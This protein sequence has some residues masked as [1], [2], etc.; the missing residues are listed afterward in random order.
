MKNHQKLALIQAILDN[1]RAFAAVD[2]RSVDMHV[3]NKCAM[4]HTWHEAA[5]VVRNTPWLLHNEKLRLY[6]ITQHG[7]Y[8]TPHGVAGKIEF[9]NRAV[10]FINA[11]ARV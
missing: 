8:N 1:V 4:G 11:I 3:Y 2:A 9:C 7:R 6:A 5:K 10:A